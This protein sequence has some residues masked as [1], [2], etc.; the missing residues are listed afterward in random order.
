MLYD[1]VAVRDNI[2]NRDGRRVFYLGKGDNL[3]SDARDYLTRERIEI[4]PA[5]EAKPDR[6][7]LLS[8]GYMEGKPEHMTHLNGEYL[9]EKTHPRIVFRGAVDTLEAELLLCAAN[10]TGEIRKQLEEALTYTR[11]LLKNEVLDEPV[12]AETLGG[13]DEK[14]LRER[15]HR[16]Q[17]FYGQPHFMPAPTDSMLLLQVNKARCA[18]RAAE[19]R[20]VA[21]FPAGREDLLRAFNRLSSFLYLIMIQLKK[22][23]LV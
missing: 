13:M 15:S 4:L 6:Y 11:T 8:G 22:G 16:P 21:A 3:T 9:V 10:A 23:P 5:S 20:A 1:K 2:R 19:L 12:K 17:D 7:R 18:A 14:A